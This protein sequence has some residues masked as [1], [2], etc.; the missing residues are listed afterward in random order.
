[1]RMSRCRPESSSR[2]LS[3]VLTLVLPIGLVLSVLFLPLLVTI[4]QQG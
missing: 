1:M 2:I 4:T 3:S